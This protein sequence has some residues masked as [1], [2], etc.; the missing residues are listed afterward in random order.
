MSR[1]YVNECAYATKELARAIDDRDTA[2]ALGLWEFGKDSWNSYLSIVN[3]SISPK[4]GDKFE[5]IS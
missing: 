1:Y 4:V 3:R 2:T 5:M